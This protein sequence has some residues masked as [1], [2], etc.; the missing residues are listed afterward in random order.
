MQSDLQSCIFSYIKW[1]CVVTLQAPNLR[2]SV[3]PSGI[4]GDETMDTI[5]DVTHLSVRFGRHFALRDL[6]FAVERGTSL[7]ILGPN[8]AGKTVLFRALVGATPFDGTV[9]WAPGTRIGY[10]PQKLDL[11]RD[12]PITGLDFLN[13]RIALAHGTGTDISRMLTMVGISPDVANQPIG[14]LSGGQ[15][16]RLL[17][18]FALVGDPNTLLLDEPTAGVDGP[19]QEQINE[20]VSILQREHALTVLFISH[21]LTMVSRYATNV[22]CLSR[23]VA[24]FG[25]P[26]TVL[27]PN[28]LRDMYGT[29]VHY[30]FHNHANER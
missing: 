8:G 1:K 17:L 20:L 2:L 29:D 12:I 16:Q 13:A 11:E 23:G 15:F 14:V 30:H 18:A 4:L 9:R 26:S 25:P 6:N 5:L 22:L 7:A 28:L 27:T 21:E 24:C 10:V 3:P 19:G